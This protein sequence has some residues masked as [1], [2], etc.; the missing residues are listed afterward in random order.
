M[1]K[2]DDVFCLDDIAMYRLEDT[3]QSF[4]SSRIYTSKD[5]GVLLERIKHKEELYKVRFFF[6]KRIEV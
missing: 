2:R 3:G 4:G 5:Y 6:M 1:F